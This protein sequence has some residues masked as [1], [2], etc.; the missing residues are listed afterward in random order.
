MCLSIISVG[1]QVLH[2]RTNDFLPAAQCKT[3]EHDN[4]KDLLSEK[5][6]LLVCLFWEKQ[7]N[8]IKWKFWIVQWTLHLRTSPFRPWI[9]SF[10]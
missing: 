9:D 5:K 2:Q 1:G 10:L 8:N 4:S 6:H 3:T 7:K